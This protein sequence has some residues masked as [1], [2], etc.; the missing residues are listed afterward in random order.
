MPAGPDRFWRK[1]VALDAV[2]GARPIAVALNVVRE[3]LRSRAL[4]VLTGVGVLLMFLMLVTGGGSVRDPAGNDLLADASGAMR[5][6]FAMAGFIG[7]VVTVVLSMNTVPREFERGTAELLLVRPAPRW[8]IGAGFVLGNVLSGWLFLLV[9]AVPLF[10]ALTVRGGWD[11]VPALPLALAGLLLNIA[12]VA[13]L[14]TL[15]SLWLPGPAAGFLG[16]LAY[17]LGAFGPELSA[18]VSLSDAWWPPL[19]RAA[20]TALPPTGAVTASV[21]QVFVPGGAVDPRP[22]LGG[23]LYLWAAGGLTAAA[24]GW[25]EAGR[26]AVVSYLGAG[27]LLAAALAAAPDPLDWTGEDAA[28]LRAALHRAAEA[29]GRFEGWDPARTPVLLTKGPVNYLVN[30][31]AEAGAPPGRPVADGSLRV[32]RL[33]EPEIPVVA[34]GIWKVGDRPVAVVAGRRQF[35]RAVGALEAG[36]GLLEGGE[37]GLLRRLLRA[38]AEARVTDEQYLGAVVHELFHA[39]QM[40]V[41]ERWVSGW[42]DA[43]D[44]TRLWHEL[45]REAENNRLQRREAERLLAAAQAAVRAEDESHVRAEAAAFLAVRDARATYWR[46]RLGAEA[47]NPLLEVEQFYE[48]LEGLARYVQ[49]HAEEGGADA[50]LAEL[51]KLVDEAGAPRARVYILGAA[52]ALAL[53]R[54]SPGWQ[55][56]AMQGVSLEALLR[57]AVAGTGAPEDPAAAGFAGGS[58]EP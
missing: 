21:L 57:E 22:L 6:G 9:L 49:A 13:A 3:A 41:A 56:R 54:L 39:Y 46:D 2:R 34:N 20:L 19:A 44:P 42:G 28:L 4:H 51:A 27:L 31:P 29:A 11:L 40:P 26:R 1:A 16:L 50:L 58:P 8:Q 53:D 37:A 38:G 12:A 23:L 14:T 24:F 25:R 45:Y 47:A 10:P 32:I 7:A 33:D 55:G 43:H 52:Q 30:F 5:V 17:G 15:L 35:D 18:L 36:A 48:W